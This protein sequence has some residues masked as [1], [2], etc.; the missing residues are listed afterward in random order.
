M[1]IDS[2][3]VRKTIVQSDFD[4]TITEQDVSF[5]L[6][7]A[8]AN[9]DW[10]PLLREYRE[11]KISVNSFN[12][13]AFGMIKADKSTLVDFA[14]KTMQIRPGFQQLVSYCQQRDYRFVIVSNGL[15]FYIEAILNDIGIDNVEIFAAKT[16]FISG[17]LEVAYIGPDGNQL[18]E[19]FKKAYTRLFLDEGYRVIYLGNGISD[20]SPAS[21]AHHI[22][23]TGE[24]ET[25]YDKERT[26]FTA[27]T[28]LNDIVQTLES[29]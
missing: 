16:E 5:M 11:N 20:I 22:F 3:E 24:L 14:K 15:D 29:L 7:D 13:R 10:R 4:G 28:N 26:N 18:E 1:T 21:Q 17:G 2:V 23:A 8:F 6:L 12:S 27:F 19:G 9:G 25:Y